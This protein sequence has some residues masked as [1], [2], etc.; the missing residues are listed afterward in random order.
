[1]K[2]II[3][4]FR[5]KRENGL[6]LLDLGTGIGKTTEVLD[7]IFDESLKTNQRFI[8]ITTLNK[9]LSDP[10]EVL[11][12]KFENND[13]KDFFDKK[14]IQIKSN[15]DY[16]IENL[17]EDVFETMP[18]EIRDNIV[19]KDLIDSIRMLKN[20]YGKDEFK[21]YIIN[22]LKNNNLEKK[23]RSLIKGYLK[24]S[25]GNSKKD[26]LNALKYDK[27]YTWI[28]KI[29]P[30]V[31]TSEK[32]IIFINVSKFLVT[33]STLVEPDYLFYQNSEILK[34]AVIFIDEFDSTKTT[35]LNHITENNKKNIDCV[36]L[37]SR[38]YDKLQSNYNKLPTDLT[39]LSD[40]FKINNNVREADCLKQDV[41]KLKQLGDDINKTYSLNMAIQSKTEEQDS[42]IFLFQD[43]E[44]ISIN[45]KNKYLQIT[46]NKK[47]KVNELRFT[48]KKPKSEENVLVLLSKLNQF[49][50]SFVNLTRRLSYNYM[51]K[52]NVADCKLKNA[53]YEERFSLE[54]SINTVLNI[55]AI[56]ESSTYCSYLRERV[57]NTEFSLHNHFNKDH[58]YFPQFDFYSK[59][60]NLYFIENKQDHDLQSKIMMTKF[61][62][63][64]EVILLNVCLKAHVIGISATANIP[65]S[66]SNYD[67]QFLKSCLG[68]DFY[69]LDLDEKEYLKNKIDHLQI[70][71]KDVNV[72]IEWIGPESYQLS[73]IFGSEAV[74]KEAVDNLSP[75]LGN[76]KYLIERYF[77]LSY[78]F[79]KF[80]S[81]DEIYSLLAI[82][83]SHINAAN[84]KKNPE[85]LDRL[86]SYISNTIDKPYY[87]IHSENATLFSL[88]GK[89]YDSKKENMLKRLANMEKIFVH[90]VFSTVGAGQNLQY[91]IPQNL[92]ESLIQ[93]NDRTSN[94]K[95]FDA[96]YIEKPTNVIVNSQSNNPLSTQEFYL[97]L[98][99]IEYL[100]EAGEISFNEKV[101]SI[102]KSFSNYQGSKN[103]KKNREGVKLHDCKSVVLAQLK[104]VGQAEGRICRTPNKNRNIYIFI[105]ES[106]KYNAYISMIDFSFF[107][108]ETKCLMKAIQSNNEVLNQ[109]EEECFTN[110]VDKKSN[111]SMQEIQYLLSRIRYDDM[112][113]KA[114]NYRREETLKYPTCSEES[115][116]EDKEKRYMYIPFKN[117]ANQY[118]YSESAD[119]KHNHIYFYNKTEDKYKMVS[120]EACRLSVCMAN[121]EISSFFI[122][123]GY[124]T[125]FEVNPYILTP[126]YFNNVY[127]G[128]L[129]EVVGKF[130]LEKYLSILLL[131]IEKLEYFELFDFKIKN[132]P[133]Y[134]DFKN[135]SRRTEFKEDIMIDKILNKADQIEDCK[136]VLVIN[137]CLQ[138]KMSVKVIQTKRKRCEKI[139]EIPSLLLQS[140]DGSTVI[141]QKIIY[142]IGGII[143]EFSN[144]D[145]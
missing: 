145:K 28:S 113:I 90:S 27:N 88:D 40:K 79:K 111:I 35:I 7:Y 96:I 48:D 112:A 89:D 136:C 36:Y 120:Q 64:P 67:L 53:C 121:D 57:L 72:N 82:T 94:Q 116:I 84:N 68:H 19:A 107:N 102:K 104:E 97:S 47:E 91:L 141:N 9:N 108:Y 8:F 98:F 83:N 18:A 2:R 39:I 61:D 70:G 127:K 14:A 137:L 105:D 122:K 75:R 60:I 86:F 134:V 77:N 32:Q 16:V 4:N 106:L 26:K 15:I 66:I 132:K 99:Q 144:N 31:F 80:L 131:P 140:E 17:T 44:Y 24:E 78:V 38:I 59:G 130:I 41:Y 42:N 63:T 118:Y 21:S 65:T 23:F 142:K 139:V 33:N 124:A 73:E 5:V 85:Y 71:Y 103:N 81:N 95:D 34:D 119:Y 115:F 50:T 3:D 128:A 20:N 76:R 109:M 58:N 62:Q 87:D 25:F 45:E 11:K 93:V 123:Q 29:Y 49:I 56:D 13:N 138:E 92:S 133:I 30:T 12:K 143:H 100:Y 22:L 51:Y 46:A 37:F 55:F 117:P 129:G 74:A 101:I 110:I 114:W 126:A 69:Q 43:S 54:S 135:F 6:L 52:K 125:T 10:F 1:M